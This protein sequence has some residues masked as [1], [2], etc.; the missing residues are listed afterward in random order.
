MKNVAAG[1]N[2]M[3]L[4]KGIEAAVEE[5][6]A[7][8]KE[9]SKPVSGKQEIAQVASISASD[10]RVGAL[11]SDAMEKVGN[12]GVIT[13][14]EGKTMKTELNV[15]EG[16]QF[17]RGYASAYMVTDSDKMEAVLDDPYI[18]ITEKKSATSRRFCPFSNLS[19]SRAKSCS[20]LRKM[21]RRCACNSRCEQASRH[22]HLRCGKSPGFGDRRKEMLKDIATLTGGEV[23]SEE[24][25]MDLKETTLNQLGRA[26]QVRVDKENTTIVEGAGNQEAIAARVKQIRAQIAETTSE[27]DKEKLQERLAKLAGGVAVISVGAATEP[28]MKE[29]KMR[30]EDA[31][32]ATR[33]AVEEGIVPG[34]GIAL[35]SVIDRVKALETKTKAIS[36]PALQ[37]SSALLK[38]PS[39]RSVQMRALKAALSLQTSAVQASLAMA[40]TQRKMNTA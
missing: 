39:A 9:I 14:E 12:D 31:L 29:I 7:G 13:I 5:A 6:V 28:E 10:E 18:L 1:A 25:G 11:I 35:L 36:A 17:D 24:L 38:S 37:L 32:N 4:R 8:L 19:H 23:V 15:V 40:T 34:G 3:V 21:L 16:M 33:A 20:S 2:P 27:Y 30:I 22:L 26:R